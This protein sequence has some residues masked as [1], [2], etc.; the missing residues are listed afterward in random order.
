VL[1]VPGALVAIALVPLFMSSVMSGMTDVSPIRMFLNLS[2]DRLVI[3]FSVLAACAS[4]LVFGL[5]PALRISGVDLQ[6]VMKDDLSPRAAAKGR[7]RMGLVISQVAVSL[8]LLVGAGLVTR[9]LDAARNA[10]PGF[11][12]DNVISTRIDLVAIGYDETGGRE[13]FVQLLDRVRANPA[14]ASATL[15]VSPPLTLVDSGDRQVTIDGYDPQP[16]EDL[17]FLSNVIAPDYFRTLRIELL[18]GREFESRD[19]MAATPVT[20]VNETLARRFWG[21]PITALGR[22][23]RVASAEW[24]TVIGVARDIKYSRFNEKPRPY[25]YLPFLQVYQPAMMFHARASVGVDALTTQMRAEIQKLDPELPL[26]DVSTLRDMARANMVFLEMAAGGLFVF[27]VAG[28][29][30]AAMGIYGLV[31]YTVRQSAHEIGIRMA[32]GA[33]GIEVVWHFLRRG[34]RLGT[35]GAVVGMVTA[36]ALTRLLGSV[37]YGVSATDPSSFA[38]ALAVVLG[39]VIVATIVPAWRAARTNPLTA[40]RQ[41]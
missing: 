26:G 29:A 6:S 16:G 33:R 28:L 13:F 22:R 18:A 1:A 35:V 20:I 34:L 21:D 19:D 4:A 10:N 37:L 17:S 24:R 41:R 9:S 30:L 40:L 36:L 2:V 8:L 11:D 31:S 39:G 15:A 12:G 14:A 27:G 32:L 25:V 23:V 38:S 5:V 7:F 3:A